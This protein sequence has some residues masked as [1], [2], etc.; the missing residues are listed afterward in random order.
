VENNRT[1]ERS[2]LEAKAMFVFIGAAP[3]T[4]W[5][6]GEIALDNQGF[7][8]AGRDGQPFMR[9]EPEDS[10][11]DPDGVP[12]AVESNRPGVFAAGDVRSGSIKCLASSVGEGAMAV[13][14]VH[15]RIRQP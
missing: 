12:M 4:Q 11:R 1:G 2:T 8:M 10:P 9:E 6:A 5:L 14:L 3:G 15:E 13:R 7:V